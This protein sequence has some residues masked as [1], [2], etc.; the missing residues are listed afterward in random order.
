MNINV[1]IDAISFYTSHY[2]LDL[3]TLAHAR[4]VD[5]DRFYADLGQRKMAVV[6]PDADIV[7][8]A[9]NAAANVLMQTQCAKHDIAMILF[10]TE[11]GVDCSKGAGMYIHEFLD[12]PVHCRVV[13][14][15]QA[16][17]G[18]TAALQLALP[19][20]R[21]HPDK[22]VLLLAADIARY[23]MHSTAE[24]SQGC[25]AVAMLLSANPRLLTIESESGVCAKEV[26]DFWRPNY[27]DAALVDGWLSCDT[28]L[29]MLQIAWQDYQTL[30]GRGFDAHQ[31]FCYHTPVSKLVESAHRRLVKINGRKRLSTEEF[32]E[33]V[34][35]S[36][37]Y[38][39]EIG[40]IYTGSLYL[41]IVSL[42][43]NVTSDLA[44]QRIGLYSYGS[45]SMAEYFSAVVVD[46][47]RSWLTP[48]L[49]Q[50]LLAER[51]ALT[52]SEYE[53]FYKFKLPQDG[54]SFVLPIYKTGKYR[55]AKLENHQRLYAKIDGE[56][57]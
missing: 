27:C 31:Y 1:G 46:G 18:A 14:L 23:T 43:E 3:Q 28:Y 11:S 30:S 45:G 38:G 34:G 4:G 57:K 37:I 9:A 48:K 36:L 19:F 24:S 47:Y 49:H 21:Q 44:G 53:D 17:Y 55:L 54:S 39:R 40:N 33:Q 8:L 10:A 56:E 32:E 6:S 16:C 13:E 41:S 22:K 29:K 51:Q 35:A 52:Y 26:M 25:G 12:M 7:T 20:L 15:K 42:L 2:Y 50:T 5:V